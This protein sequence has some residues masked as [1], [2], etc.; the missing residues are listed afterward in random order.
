MIN[1]IENTTH[2]EAIMTIAVKKWT[3]KEV[4]SAV[5]IWNQI[6]EEGKAF[7]QTNLLT[8]EEGEAF[9]AKQDYTGIAYD[10]ESGA[11]VGLYILHPNNVGRCGHIA[12]TS[13][14]VDREVRGQHIGRLLVEDS[15]AQARDLGYGIIQLNAVVAT[16]QAALKLYKDIGFKQLG[17]IERGFRMDDGHYEAIIPHVYYL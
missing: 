8:Y 10:T 4:G 9:F 15:I 16:N 5:R 14:A 11:I 7:P 3:V 1:R 17:T 6:V 12:N 13:Y 2:L